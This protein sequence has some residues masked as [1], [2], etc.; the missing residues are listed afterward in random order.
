MAVTT[1]KDTG[2]TSTG[3]ASGSKSPDSGRGSG[4]CR[5]GPC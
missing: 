3:G 2:T 4:G 1:G 5:H